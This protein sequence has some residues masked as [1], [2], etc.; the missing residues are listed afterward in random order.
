MIIEIQIGNQS[1]GL[2]CSPYIIAELSVNHNSKPDTI[3][4]VTE[5]LEKTGV[6]AVKLQ[7]CKPRNK[8][9][10]TQSAVYLA[11]VLVYQSL[12]SN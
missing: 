5:E 7:I 11:P 6:D 2:E 1:N 10:H 4:C 8:L 3:L 12:N 9:R